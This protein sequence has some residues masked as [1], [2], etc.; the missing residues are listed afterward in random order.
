MSLDHAIHFVNRA[1]EESTHNLDKFPFHLLHQILLMTKNKKKP[2]SLSL[3]FGD[4]DRVN[5]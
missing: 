5:F 4:W 1:A 2:Q 3:I